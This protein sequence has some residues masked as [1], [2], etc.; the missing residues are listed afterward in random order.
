MIDA[1]LIGSRI[2]ELRQAKGLTQSE[3]ANELLVSFQAVSNWERGITPPDLEN[4]VRI[5]SFFGVLTDDLL[6]KKSDSL[7]LGIDGGGTKTEFAVVTAEGNVLSRFI[8]GG[9]NPN[10]VGFQKTL[11]IISEGIHDMLLEFSAIKSV[12]CGVAGILTGGHEKRLRDELI[13]QYP[14]LKIQIRTDS[15]NLFAMDDSSDMVVISGTGSVVFVRH[16]DTHTRIGGWGYLLD[17][18]G[19]GYDIGRDAIRAALSEEDSRKKYSCIS[20]MLCERMGVSSIGDNLGKI[21][22]GGKPYIASLASIVFDAYRI[23]DEMAAA[24]ID[25]NA[26]ALAELLNRGVE[27]YGAKPFAIAS[28]G[29]FEHYGDIICPAIKKYSGVTLKVNKL[30]PVYGACRR[31]CELE[32]KEISDNFYLNFEKTYGG[33]NI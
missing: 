21:Y 31:A 29:I 5:A 25:K 14:Q 13:K 19:S 20:K 32:K 4:L 2:R 24:I 23:G 17:E 27:L 26:L 15:F 16:G 33:H 30:P 7:F 10:D 12:F 22:G 8:R 18:A 28:G 1:K 3:F 6:R 11:S 9:C